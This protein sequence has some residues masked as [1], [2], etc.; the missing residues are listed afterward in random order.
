VEQIVMKF[1]VEC[2]D[3]FNFHSYPLS[4][5]PY[6]IVLR[7]ASVHMNESSLHLLPIFPKIRFNIILPSCKV[8]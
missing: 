8:E 3:E 6:I 4:Y 7:K 2:L 5:N 1:D